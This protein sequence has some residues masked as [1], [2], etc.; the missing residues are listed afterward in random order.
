MTRRQ[1]AAAWREI[2]RKVAER[3]PAYGN[4][5]H[6]DDGLCSHAYNLKPRVPFATAVYLFRPE[7]SLGGYFW[8]FDPRGRAC[9][10]LAALFIAAMYDS[11]DLP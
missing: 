5:T 3:E 2:A 8:D 6:Y 1:L 10:V 9:R 7:R 4:L 11:G